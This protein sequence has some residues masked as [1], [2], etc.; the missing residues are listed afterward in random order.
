MRTKR[1]R[2]LNLISVARAGQNQERK[3]PSKRQAQSWWQLWYA[4]SFS[5][6]QLLL[7]QG[8]LQAL[9]YSVLLVPAVTPAIK[10]ASDLIQELLA[11]C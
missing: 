7:F 1:R 4:E 10:A 2:S 8:K 6:N 3:R 9:V 11:D 5:R